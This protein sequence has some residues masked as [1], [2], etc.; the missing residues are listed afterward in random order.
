MK[1]NMQ[2]QRCGEAGK[3][4]AHSMPMLWACLDG[5]DVLQDDP[6]VVGHRHNL[7]SAVNQ[8]P[9][10]DERTGSQG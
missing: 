10:S 9:V 4:C 5:L 2:E 6:A 3:V 7:V 1:S 8:V